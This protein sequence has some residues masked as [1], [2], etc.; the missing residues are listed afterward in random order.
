MPDV[1]F[2]FIVIV[3]ANNIVLFGKNSQ[4]TSSLCIDTVSIW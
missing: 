1:N 2:E 4:S 3:K